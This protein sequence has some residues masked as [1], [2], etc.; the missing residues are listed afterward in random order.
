MSSAF[1]IDG[2]SNIK[3]TNCSIFGFDIGMDISTSENIS[4][5]NTSFTE[6][7]TGVRARNVQGLKAH[8]NIEHTQYSF[9]L[10]PTVIL[11]KMY[12]DYLKTR[13]I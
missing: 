3:I 13:R 8:N 7:G 1:K 2:C 6:V 11:V 4:I 5:T 12:I 10:K 9:R